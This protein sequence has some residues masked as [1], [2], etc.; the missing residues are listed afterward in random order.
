MEKGVGSCCVRTVATVSKDSTVAEAAAL[1]R[2]HHVGALVMVDASNG[3]RKPVG[4]VTDRDIAIEVVA[5]GLVPATVKVGEIVQR[6]VAT[7]PDD[8]GCAEAVRLMSINGVRRMPVVDGAGSLI[9][10]VSFDDLLVQ[11]VT[12]LVAIAD[13]AGRGRNFEA[14][15]RG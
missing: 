8:A 14:S 12:P 2:K 5:E 4:I 11:L 1:M 13:L 10:I 7:V 15:T 6:K 9:G 3:A